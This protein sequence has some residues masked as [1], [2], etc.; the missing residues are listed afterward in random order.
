MDRL[1]VVRF[2]TRV[3]IAGPDDCWEWKGNRDEDGYGVFHLDGKNCWAVRVPLRI[4]DGKPVPDDRVVR[5][6]CD[7]PPC[8]NP[9]HL[10]G[11]SPADNA[12]DMVRRGRVARGERAGLAKLTDAD[13]SEMMNLYATGS[14]TAKDLAKRYGVAKSSIL[15]ILKGE[16]WA[17]IE[18]PNA[19]VV[20]QQAE[21]NK[22][23]RARG[24]D[25]GLAKL[26]NAQIREIY[27]RFSAGGINQTRLAEEYGVCRSTVGK[28]LRGSLWQH[29]DRDPITDTRQT[30]ARHWYYLQNPDKAPKPKQEVKQPRTQFVE[31]ECAHCGK[32]FETNHVLRKFCSRE[33]LVQSHIATAEAKRKAKVREGKPDE[34]PTCGGSVDRTRY[35]GKVYCSEDCQVKAALARRPSKAGPLQQKMCE[36]C[37]ARFETTRASRKYCTDRCNK[38]AS[39]LRRKQ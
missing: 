36:H 9:V 2:W 14:W 12:W 24:E 7:N 3:A 38:K 13:V 17:H 15:R 16:T 28:I 35:G 31:R 27:D 30:G 34:C 11:G 5:H 10:D 21:A 8:V 39:E 22:L 19:D 20:R 29:V 18:R 33:C 37:G 23:I 25:A 32:P 6:H 4:T 1:D 26:T